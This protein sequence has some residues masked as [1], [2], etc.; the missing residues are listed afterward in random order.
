MAISGAALQARGEGNEESGREGGRERSVRKQS[1]KGRRNVK[2]KVGANTRM[3]QGK[4]E[5]IE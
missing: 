1:V 4:E 2:T 3:K 5:N